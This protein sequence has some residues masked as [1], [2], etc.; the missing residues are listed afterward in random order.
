M[1]WPR[2]ALPWPCRNVPVAACDLEMLQGSL[3]VRICSLDPEDAHADVRVAL[4]K[5]SVRA[6]G[7]RLLF[8]GDESVGPRDQT[9]GAERVNK[10]WQ[11]I[12][13]ERGWNREAAQLWWQEWMNEEISNELRKQGW[14]VEGLAVTRRLSELRQR[15]GA[16]VVPYNRDRRRPTGKSDK[17]P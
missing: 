8:E 15:F 1:G 16:E 12:P 5:E 9:I 2:S 7:G 10:P 3:L 13:G 14:Y 6:F 4:L 11:R 17:D